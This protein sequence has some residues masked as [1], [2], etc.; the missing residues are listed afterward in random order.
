MVKKKIN[1]NKILCWI[2]KKTTIYYFTISKEW[3]I[4]TLI[5]FYNNQ[6]IDSLLN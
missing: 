2:K 3:D 1:E 6:S 5:H 4:Y